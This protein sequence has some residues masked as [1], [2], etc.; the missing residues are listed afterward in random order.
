MEPC[1]PIFFS[2]V[3]VQQK[4]ADARRLGPGPG[5]GEHQVIAA[6]R[7]D[8]DVDLAAREQVAALGGLGLGLQARRVRAVVRLGEAKAHGL[9]AALELAEQA[10]FLLAGAGDGDGAHHRVGDE[11]HQRRAGAG[12][13]NGLHHQGQ[14]GGVAFHAAVFLG[15]GQAKEPFAGQGF[16][17]FLRKLGRGLDVARDGSDFFAHQGLDPLVYVMLFRS[18]KKHAPSP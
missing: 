13:G 4:G 12:G 8:G 3:A 2:G 11:N 16:I 6:V 17:G 5:A 10:L 15:H 7:A 18:Q 14:A 9:V 1:R